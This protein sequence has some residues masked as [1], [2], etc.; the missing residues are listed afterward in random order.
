MA[1]QEQPT[2]AVSYKDQAGQEI[3]VGSLV[4][5]PFRVTKLA[6]STAPLLH[7]ESIDAYGHENLSAPGPLKGRTK[8]GIWVEPGQIKV[9]DSS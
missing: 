5:V 3:K 6:G 7:L 9:G 1:T 8:T 2:A 4:L